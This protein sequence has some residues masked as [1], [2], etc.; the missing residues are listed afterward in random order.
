MFADLPKFGN[1]FDEDV[2]AGFVRK[3]FGIVGAQLTLTSIICLMAT[4]SETFFLFQLN[5]FWLYVVMAIGTIVTYSML[6]CSCCGNFQHQFPAN[7]I[8]LSIF[9]LCEAYTVSCLCAF[10]TPELVSAAMTLTAI[11][12][13][14][15]LA[16]AT[17]PSTNLISFSRVIGILSVAL[18]ASSLIL[19]FVHIP[20]LHWFY[21][22]GGLVVYGFSLAFHFQ[23]VIGNKLGVQFGI[24]DYIQASLALYLD[25]VRIFIRILILLAKLTGNTNERKKK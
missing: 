13:M 20:I 9:T 5:N 24:D 21:L 23:L 1:S 16:F 22:L 11:M 15:V 19:F 6:V 3:V 4:I 18:L 14:G 8:L 25:I 12:T 17:S 10:F 2:R 7:F